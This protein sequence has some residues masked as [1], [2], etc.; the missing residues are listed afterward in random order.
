VDNLTHTLVGWML[1]RGGLNRAGRGATL[2]LVLAANAPDIDIVTAAGGALN[3]LRYHRGVTHALAG[4]PVLA[5]AVTA[6]VWLLFRKRGF[7]WGRMYGLALAGVATHPLL[8]MMNTYGVRVL[9]PFSDRWYSWDLLHIVDPWLWAGLFFCVGAAFLGRLIS[10]EIGAAPGSGRRWALAGL[11][12]V[13]AWCATRAALHQRVVA[14]LESHAYGLDGE[15][16]PPLRVAAFPVP[17]S[18]FTWRG[19][20]ETEE[21]YQLLAADPREPLDPTRGEVQYK[22]E[23]SP[24]LEVARRSPTWREF[25]RF[26]QYPL[27]RVERTRVTATD[28]RF[29]RERREAFI[30]VVEMDEAGRVVE[31]RFRF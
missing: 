6:L 31:E 1:A 27:V 19:L 13:T 15:R 18:P 17:T 16:R 29:L 23:P 5:L 24:P 8:D 22:P 21:F 30:C 20:V 26:A 14:M 28:F 10:G 7:C 11:A 2:A 25:A 4:I 3:Y 12:F 9:E